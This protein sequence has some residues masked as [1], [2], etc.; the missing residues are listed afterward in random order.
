VNAQF[1]SFLRIGDH[2]S[3][4]PGT[5][6]PYIGNTVWHYEIEGLTAG[7]IK[8]LR[9][10][11][12]RDALRFGISASYRFA[13]YASAIGYS[14]GEIFVLDSRAPL[15]ENESLQAVRLPL[16]SEDEQEFHFKPEGAMT[17]LE[18]ARSLGATMEGA[19]RA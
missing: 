4:H 3:V 8:A 11:G 19:P 6:T 2:W 17:F 10:G 14:L 16:S 5:I 12:V 1:S 9:V 7:D 13:S 15:M 18:Y